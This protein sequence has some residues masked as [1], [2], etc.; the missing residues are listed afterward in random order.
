MALVEIFLLRISHPES[1]GNGPQQEPPFY[2][3]HIYTRNH[4]KSRVLVVFGIGS[5]VVASEVTTVVNYADGPGVMS[6]CGDR[7]SLTR[8]PH[9]Q[10][11][12]RYA[13]TISKCLRRMWDSL[14]LSFCISRHQRRENLGMHPYLAINQICRPSRFMK[15]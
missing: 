10:L 14:R 3:R 15:E 4:P 8:L 1:R 12:V 2:L 7:T 13:S 6:E 11:I 9:A 5:L